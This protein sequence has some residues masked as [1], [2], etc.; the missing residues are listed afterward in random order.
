MKQVRIHWLLQLV[1]INKTQ[2]FN[3]SLLD[4]LLD[5]VTEDQTNHYCA[6][7]NLI[8]VAAWPGPRF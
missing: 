1:T 2:G 4:Q 5:K 6:C 8:V 3:F 7:F